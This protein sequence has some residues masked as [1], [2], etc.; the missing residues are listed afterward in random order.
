MNDLTVL[1]IDHK[2]KRARR[3]LLCRC[4]CGNEKII[5]G[6]LITSGNTKSCGCRVAKAQQ[7]RRLPDNKGVINH[8]ILQYKRLARNRNFEFALTYDDFS[9]L[10]SKNC[11]YCGSP[12]SNI[13]RTKNCKEGFI[14]SGIDRLDSSLGYYPENSVPACAICNRAKNDLS[15]AEFRGWVLK[16]SAMAE[17]WG[18]LL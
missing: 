11:Y 9:N 6:S 13:K 3:F 14:Y 5:Q 15:V 2:D 1:A 16:L 8:L 18:N 10:I 17:Q 12:P 7:F 4:I